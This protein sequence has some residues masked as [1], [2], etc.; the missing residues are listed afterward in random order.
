[1]VAEDKLTALGAFAYDLVKRYSVPPYNIKYWELWNEPD[2]ADFMGCWGDPADTNYFGGY[3]YGQML[4]VV[5]PMMKAADPQAQVLVGGLLLDCDPN[6]PPVG[7]TCVESQF[8]RGILENGA[9]DSF[10]GVAF[11]GYD[12]YY[13]LGYYGNSNW[14]SSSTTTGPVLLAKAHYLEALLAEYGQ[15]HKYLANTETAIFY[16]PY[17]TTILCISYAPPEVQI[18]KAY[19]VIHTYAVAVAEGWKTNIWYSAFGLRCSGLLQTDLT[20]LPA[21]YA[22]QVAEQKLGNA[23]FVREITEYPGVKGYEYIMQGKQLWVL[24][25]L[26][27]NPDLIS[28]SQMPD[29]ITRIGEDGKPVIEPNSTSLTID[30]SPRFI[31]FQDTLR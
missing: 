31:E 26:D 1:M 12:Y 13:G 7:R 21:Y 30:L 16:G 17:D 19:Y 18:T 27:S 4:K 24:W 25:S 9:G 8:L 3:Y 2:A 5:Y 10:D 14:H 23:Q 6:N 28:L 15:S 22:Y 20:P 29:L 11:H